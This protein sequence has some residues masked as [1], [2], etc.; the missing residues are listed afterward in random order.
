MLPL[1]IIRGKPTCGHFTTGFGIFGTSNRNEKGVNKMYQL[2]LCTLIVLAG[3]C[4]LN[5][6]AIVSSPA[7][8]AI[9]I[10]ANDQW[11][12]LVQS[13][14]N[15]IKAGSA[16]DLSS[17]QRDGTVDELG[18]IVIKDG[19]FVFADNPE[20]QVRFLT[21]AVTPWKDFEN[22]GHRE[23][24]EFAGEIRRSGYNMVRTHFLDYSLMRGMSDDLEFSKEMQDKIDYF[25]YC[26]KKNGIYLNFDC[27]TSW[28]GY[29]AGNMFKKKA[30]EISLK[31]RIYHD[32]AVR[33]NWRKG[34]ERILCRINPYTGMRLIDD[35]VLVMAVAYNEQEYG[36]WSGKY[37]GAWWLP[38][39]RDFLR[40]KYGSI[41]DL[42]Q[43]WGTR[44]DKFKRFE[45]IP[46]PAGELKRNINPLDAAEFLIPLEQ[47]MAHWY[48]A[49]MKEMGFRGFLTNSNCIANSCYNYLRK[50]WPLTAM[51]QYHAHPKGWISP[52]S[53]IEQNSPIASGAQVFRYFAGARQAEKPFVVTEHN[54]CFWNRYRY[55]QAFV[56]G[57]YSAFQD[58]DVLTCHS[59]SVSFQKVDAIKTFFLWTDPIA[60]ASEFLT[61]F[62][63]RRQDV[64]ATKPAIRIRSARKS[65]IF[66]KTVGL[67]NMSWG[68]PSQ[69]S[70][71]ALIA[72]FSTETTETPKEWRQL[73]PGELAF[74]TDFF[75]DKRGKE[76]NVSNELLTAMRKA[77]IISPD[78]RSNGKTI[79]ESSTQELLLDR[80][81]KYMQ[82]DTPRFQGVCAPAGVKARLS[83]FEIRD[84][85]TDGNLAL[86]SVDDCK[87]L[88]EAK[89][90]VLVYMTNALNT[91]MEFSSPEMTKLLKCGTVPVLIQHGSFTVVIKNRHAPALK[92]YPLDMTGNRLKELSAIG[93]SDTECV[94]SYDNREGI[95]YF[96]ISTE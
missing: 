49:Q 87:P 33:D 1:P 19:H 95:I 9:K 15:R 90:M 79:F 85:T 66:R 62:L 76:R 25:I 80:E 70:M 50:E 22:L 51:N 26:I 8:T 96:E 18:R 91:N 94:F 17:F 38:R 52:N 35:P 65:D 44:A 6:A 82:I 59:A 5:A 56:I 40:K 68:M 4:S 7:S 92:L 89:R 36:L 29:T 84:M 53:V 61:F 46:A 78:N 47:E 60:K 14:S 45:D 69:Q 55:E 58:I 39:W 34:V 21:N 73:R 3:E 86:V 23:L 2:L 41:R 43:A 88:E 72:G 75:Y 32:P 28:I 83:N 71:P 27:M 63:F 64:T 48:A 42:K 57:G 12:P 81:R 67:P 74:S 13:A 20:V 11:V 37:D 10:Q 30:P 24:E 16:L 77:G 93:G 54:V 31:S